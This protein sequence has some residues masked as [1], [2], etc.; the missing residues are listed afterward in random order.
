MSST[1]RICIY[2]KDIMKI[3]GKSERYC[4]KVLEKIKTEY[5]KEKHQAV[6][7]NEFCRYYGLEI[8]LVQPFLED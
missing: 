3:T 6:S 4:R 8:E 1:K 7:V 5:A 2:A